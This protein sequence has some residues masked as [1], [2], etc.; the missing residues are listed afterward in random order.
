DALRG[1]PGMDVTEFGA[2]GQTAFAT[3]RG[4]NPDQVLV[5][6]DGVEVNTPTVGQFDFGNLTT[7]NIDRIE[8]LRGGG[9]TLYGS[10]AIGGV[11][12]VL[13]QRGEGP[14]H[15]LAGAEAGSAATHHESLGINGAH[16]PFSLSGTASFLATDGFRSINDDYR[17]FST[18][19]R[20]DLDLLPAGT[21]RGFLRYSES[22]T[23]LVNFNVFQNQLDPDAHA[24]DNF[25]LAKGE[26]EHAPTDTFNYRTAVS[27]VRDN[28]RYR[29][30]MVDD[31]GE[32][33]PVVI[34]HTPSEQIEAEVQANARWPECALTT[35][36]LEYKEQWAEFDEF[37]ADSED[38]PDAAGAASTGRS[39]RQP[40]AVVR[41][42]DA[43]GSASVMRANRSIVGVYGQEQL[44]LLDDALRGVGGIRYDHY[45]V[46]G[47][48]TTLS[49]SGSYLI[50]PTQTRLRVGYAE[51]FRAPTFD[52]LFGALG[53]PTLK[54]ET[55]WEIDAGLTQEVF[56]GRLRLEPTYF[57][58]EM[59]NLIEEIADELPPVAG[60]PEAEGTRNVA[61]TR[62]QGM[63][64]IARL[65]P[66]QWLTLAGNYTYLNFVTPT[67]ALV[68]RPRHRGSA[69]AMGHWDD[70]F[71]AG[72]HTTLSTL[73]YL[74]GHR[75]SPNP[76]DME[77][78]FSPAP[79][80]G[81]GRVDVAL[82]YHFGGRLPALSLTASA[83]N[84]LNRDYAESIGFPAPPANFL[85]GI[86]YAFN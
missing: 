17:N 6:L 35:V 46:F 45:D 37:A 77:E 26:W 38:A 12:N 5:L 53:N 80:A 27:F 67:G 72:D 8:I 33:E 42:D 56:G 43:T 61:G 9:G 40:P 34:S 70:L 60:V 75:D 62:M 65:Q 18:V 11:V 78:P 59:H 57:Y 79:I 74:V 39:A 85:A 23:G 20:S 2:A 29:D 66:T 7:D 48:Q 50:R 47:D 1:A 21:L 51:G 58:R 54:P 84:L 64:L 3:I 22:R 25:F 82:A 30:D 36:G 32:V 41:A 15:L 71:A 76:F 81:Y 28:P 52:E 24:R 86:R 69:T 83:R 73:V 49:G 13:T 16:G 10:E 55:S 4:S 68:N 63:E 44:Q 19:W 31:E 14:F